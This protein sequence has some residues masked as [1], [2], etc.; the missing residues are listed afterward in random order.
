MSTIHHTD[1]V[2]E[3]AAVEVQGVSRQ[4]F[5]VRGALAAG[6]V[7]GTTMISPFVRGAF[8]AEGMGD[9]DI[10]NFALTL[11][12]L[13]AD[14]YRRALKLGLSSEVAKVAR[15][16]GDAEQQHVDALAATIKK[17]GGTPVASPK[18]SFPMKDEKSFLKLA[19]TLEDTGV[20]AY[21]GAGPAITSKEVLAAAG[22]IVQVEARHAAVIRQLR[23]NV[24]AP[25]AFDASLDTKQVLAAVK[26][27][28]R[29]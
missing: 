20:S 5:L 9:V 3:L 24:P 14:F 11:E 10:L 15:S 29:S 13:E 16:F 28:I 12:Y 18:F 19:Q 25:D 27:L 1:L 17:L 2:P 6:A 4:A 8:A 21:N 7:Y 22:S 23:G 26:P